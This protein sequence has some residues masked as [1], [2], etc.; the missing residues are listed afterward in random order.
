MPTRSI[1]LRPHKQWFLAA[2][3]RERSLQ[4]QHSDTKRHYDT[5]TRDLS[6]LSVGDKVMVQDH[7]GKRR[8]SR[9][10]VV[11]ERNGRRYTVRMDGSGRIVLRNRRFLRSVMRSSFTDQSTSLDPLPEPHISIQDDELISI[12]Q[13]T[14]DSQTPARDTN[15]ESAQHDSVPD[16]TTNTSQP[17]STRT[18]LML[19]RLYPHNHQGLQE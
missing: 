13:P 17:S 8:W 10:G 15:T 14:N 16:V 2:K 12:P 19:R 1:L 18:P 3:N 9:S 5:F 4:Q 11:V 7:D 6:P